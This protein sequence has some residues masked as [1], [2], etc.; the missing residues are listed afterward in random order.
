MGLFSWPFEVGNLGEDSFEWVE[1]LVDTGAIYSSLPASTL[2]RLGVEATEVVE[3]ELADGSIIE[4][5]LGDGRARVE[6]REVIT[7]FVFGDET[8]TPLLGAYTLERVHLAVDSYG[9]RLIPV[10][11]SLKAAT[12]HPDNLP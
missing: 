8:D 1:G 9:R 12:A 11:A 5:P 10:R 7:A 6:G 2:R 3:F 4:R